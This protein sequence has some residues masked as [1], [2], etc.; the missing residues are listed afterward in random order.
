VAHDPQE[1]Y[2]IWRWAQGPDSILG[3][4]WADPRDFHRIF[5]DEAIV[6]VGR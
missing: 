3:E 1:S 5:V 2:Q 6:E 4:F